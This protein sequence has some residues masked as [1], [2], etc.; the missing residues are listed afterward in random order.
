MLKQRSPK[1]VHV[2]ARVCKDPLQNLLGIL[3]PLQ[4]TTARNC[5][6]CGRLNRI[7]WRAIGEVQR[8]IYGRRSVAS[9]A[10]ITAVQS[11]S[12]GWSAQ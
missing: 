8:Q 3:M 6:L 1:T 2:A 10:V 4:S 7:T 9:R 5:T 12:A 11:E